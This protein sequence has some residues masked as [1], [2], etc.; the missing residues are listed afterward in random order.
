M[1]GALSREAYPSRVLKEQ[2]RL[3]SGK[4]EMGRKGRKESPRQPQSRRKGSFAN[5]GYAKLPKQATG[6]VGRVDAPASATFAPWDWLFAA[7]L[8]VAV[9]LVYQPAWQGGFLW[10]DE[11][12]LLNNPV[13]KP[14]GLATVWMPGGYRYNYWPLTFTA[15][16]LQF[17][18]WGLDSAGLPFGEHRVACRFGAAGVANARAAASARRDVCGG[19]FR[20]ASR[21]MSRAWPGSRN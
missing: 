19:D 20:P 21:S 2:Y 17:K 18:I 16:W 7:A 3:A 10:D 4:H 9:F 8:V 5:G 11:N 14:G 6:S 1:A 12:H 13:L 15:Y